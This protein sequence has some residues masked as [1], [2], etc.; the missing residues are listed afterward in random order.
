VGDD[1][2]IAIDLEGELLLAGPVPRPHSGATSRPARPSRTR[3]AGW[4]SSI[5]AIWLASAEGEAFGLSLLHRT[6]T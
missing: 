5:V 4:P 6:A 1:Q 3:D 2:T